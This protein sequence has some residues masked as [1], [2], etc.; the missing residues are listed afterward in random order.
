MSSASERL[1]AVAHA[2]QDAVEALADV[3]GDVGGA[4]HDTVKV[5]EI[6]EN[7]D[8]TPEQLLARVRQ[9]RASALAVARRATA[10]PR[11]GRDPTGQ[12]PG[13]R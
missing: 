13:T 11:I 1:L 9:F 5:P 3:L 12:V 8:S 4:L 6:A 7:F 2:A 10:R